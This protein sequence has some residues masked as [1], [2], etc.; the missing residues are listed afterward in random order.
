MVEYI[1][2]KRGSYVV[3][4]NER[5]RSIKL[6]MDYLKAVSFHSNDWQLFL[7]AL[8][9]TKMT[10]LEIAECV[11]GNKFNDEQ[12]KAIWTMLEMILEKNITLVQKYFESH[13]NKCFSKYFHF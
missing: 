6:R 7:E 5:F 10:L 12:E 2:H 11:F 9:D 8:N 13:V 4:D 1:H 3:V